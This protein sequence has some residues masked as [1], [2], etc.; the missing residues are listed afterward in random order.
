[1]D[2][3]KETALL[4]AVYG[5]S[6][7]RLEELRGQRTLFD[8]DRQIPQNNLYGVDLNEEAIHSGLGGRLLAFLTPSDFLVAVPQQ[9]PDKGTQMVRCFWSMVASARASGPRWVGKPTNI[10]RF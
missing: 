6:N 8:L 7:A 2:E 9:V 1:V 10:E 4:H 5:L 3:F